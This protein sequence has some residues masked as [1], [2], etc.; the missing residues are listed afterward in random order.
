VKFSEDKCKVL[1]LEWNKP[2]Q[3]H[4]LDANW[5][6]SSLA[7]KDLGVLVDKLTM[8]HCSMAYC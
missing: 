4:R 2:M 1:Q 8:S 5:L 7:E 6:C 3:Q